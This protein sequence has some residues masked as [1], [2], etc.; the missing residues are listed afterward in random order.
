MLLSAICSCQTRIT[1]L[2]AMVKQASHRKALRTDVYKR[3]VCESRAPCLPNLLV[4]STKNISPFFLRVQAAVS[5][6]ALDDVLDVQELED[7]Y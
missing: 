4:A 3:R 6:L 1:H 5:L 7:V 2:G